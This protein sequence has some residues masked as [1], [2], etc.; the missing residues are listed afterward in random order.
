M[1]VKLDVSHKNMLLTSLSVIVL[2]F[3]LFVCL[4]AESS[5]GA[6][7][8]NAIHVKN[9]V[10][11]KN[12]IN[13][14]SN[15]GLVT[16]ALDNDITLTETLTIQGS[17]DLTLTSNKANGFYKLIG[18]EYRSTVFVDRD[19]VLKLDTVVTKEVF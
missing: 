17:K 6:S 1:N 3:S 16:I 18:A 14:T 19:G 13:N 2:V 10:E 5:R 12:A 4:F 9:E 15:S 11:L 7:L 8:E